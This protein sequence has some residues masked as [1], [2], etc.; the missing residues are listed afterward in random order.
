MG[1]VPLGMAALVDGVGWNTTLAR[2]AARLV[3]TVSADGTWRTSD[4]LPAVGLI[5]AG[6]SFLVSYRTLATSS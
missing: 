5:L 2:A 6:T 4:S 3:P 1:C